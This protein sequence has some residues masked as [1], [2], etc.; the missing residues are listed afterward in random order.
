MGFGNAG[1]RWDGFDLHSEDRKSLQDKEL[2]VQQIESGQQL[3]KD[4]AGPLLSRQALVNTPEAGRAAASAQGEIYR[5]NVSGAAARGLMHSGSLGAIKARN[6]LAG[7]E[8]KM[9]L[10]AQELAARQQQFMDLAGMQQTLKGSEVAVPKTVTGHDTVQSRGFGLD[11]WNDNET[12]T[13]YEYQ[14]PVFVDERARIEGARREIDD[15]VAKLSQ[16]RPSQTQ[17]LQSM[18]ASVASA[19]DNYTTEQLAKAQASGMSSDQV[20]GMAGEL[21]QMRAQA[22]DRAMTISQQMAQ[23]MNSPQALSATLSALYNADTIEEIAQQRSGNSGLLGAVGRVGGLA[24]GAY[25]G[26]SPA[27]AALGYEVGGNTGDYLDEELYG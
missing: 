20:A 17:I 8:A 10:Q 4:K 9:K 5:Q 24:V 11:F 13:R 26:K 7:A 19:F 27:A 14:Q 16:R 15:M 3:A 12:T 21:Q 2:L 25:V 23:S 22:L 1:D 18:Q 6:A